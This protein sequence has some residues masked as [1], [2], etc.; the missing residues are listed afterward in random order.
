MKYRSSLGTFIELVTCTLFAVSFSVGLVVGL[1]L[2]LIAW[3]VGVAQFWACLR[4][5]LWLDGRVF[6]EAMRRDFPELDDFSK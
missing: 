2:G 3:A 5:I 6:A 1:P 4:V